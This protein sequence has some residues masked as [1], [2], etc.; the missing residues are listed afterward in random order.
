MHLDITLI[1]SDVAALCRKFAGMT[2]QFETDLQSGIATDVAAM[3]PGGAQ[4]DQDMIAM[5]QLAIK[6][7][8]LLAAAADAVGVSARFQRLGSDLTKLEHA[9]EKHTISF[10]ITSF[11]VIFHDLFG[12]E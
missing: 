11:E 7:A 1:P 4:L 6:S 8:G 3:I 10:Y 5:C 2:K 12:G 9:D